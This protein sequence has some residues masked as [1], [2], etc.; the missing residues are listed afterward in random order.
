MNLRRL[1]AMLALSVATLISAS[2]QAVVQMNGDGSVGSSTPAYSGLWN[3]YEATRLFC[4]NDYAS[5][6]K[7]QSIVGAA[8]STFLTFSLGNSAALPAVA[9]AMSFFY[10]PASGLG[11]ASTAA[12]QAYPS[13]QIWVHGTG[14]IAFGA[15]APPLILDLV[16]G[17]GTGSQIIM[18]FMGNIVPAGANGAWVQY[19][20]SFPN[21][22]IIIEWV[23]QGG[24]V[25][26][27]TPGG[28]GN[29][30]AVL[31]ESGNPT[32]TEPQGPT[33][34]KI[35]FHYG[36][37]SINMPVPTGN[38]PDRT[39][40]SIGLKNQGQILQNPPGRSG[41]NLFERF[42]LMTEPSRYQTSSNVIANVT[43]INSAVGVDSISITGMPVRS[44]TG[45]TFVSELFAY[46]PL[47]INLVTGHITSYGNEASRYF[48]YGYPAISC[49]T[50][51]YRFMP[52]V[53]DIACVTDT[54]T[55]PP[56]I[57]A[58]TTLIPSPVPANLPLPAIQNGVLAYSY[59]LNTSLTVQQRFKNIGLNPVTSTFRVDVYRHGVSLPIT[60]VSSVPTLVN[61]NTISTIAFPQIT[62]LT[63]FNQPG[64]YTFKIYNI[65]GGVN[66]A[67]QNVENDTCE[68]RVYIRF[69]DDVMA[70]SVL[71][72]NQNTPPYYTRY[73]VGVDIP[74]EFRY[75]NIGNNT[76]V[77]VPV[78][79]IVYKASSGCSGTEVWRKDSV[80]ALT[81][82]YPW[83]P[84][85][86]RDVTF[87]A[88]SVNTPPGQPLIGFRPS[89][90]GK[91]YVK[92][93]VMMNGD[94]NRSNDTVP[95]F[96]RSYPYNNEYCL[97][98]PAPIVNDIGYEF[99][100][101]L[102]KS[103]SLNPGTPYG[104][105]FNACVGRVEDLYA[106][107]LNFGSND[108]INVSSTAVITQGSPTGTQVYSSTKVTTVVPKVSPTGAPGSKTQFYDK[109]VPNAPGIYYITVTAPQAPTGQN[110][111]QWVVLVG[112]PLAGSYRIGQGERF[113]SIQD[114]RDEL[115]R[116]GV[117][118]PVVFDLIE[119]Y[120]LVSPGNQNAGVSS[121]LD[122]PPYAPFLGATNTY[123]QTFIDPA[124]V[125]RPDSIVR[126]TAT[127]PALDFRGTISGASAV[128]TITFRPAVGKVNVH[129]RLA[130][131]SGIGIWYGQDIQRTYV[132]LAQPNR[133]VN[134]TGY[135]I[136]D[137]GADK[138][139]EFTYE[140]LTSAAGSMS[141]GGDNRYYSSIPFYMG[142]G[143]SNYT[144][145][146][147]KI[148][149][150]YVA[151]TGHNEPAVVVPNLPSGFSYNVLP[152]TCGGNPN[153][154]LPN[155]PGVPYFGNSLKIV[156]Q[157]GPID[158]IN[159]KLGTQTI[160]TPQYNQGSNLF[161][162]EPDVFITNPPK[163]G[164]TLSAGV[165]MRS[166]LP[167][168]GAGNNPLRWDTL[169]NN[170]N[171]IDNNEIEN[172]AYGVVSTGI[173]AI[174]N[175][176]FNSYL[177]YPNVGNTITNNFIH[178]V[179]RAGVAVEYDRK[180]KIER[181]TIVRVVNP[182]P[183]LNPVM[184]RLPNINF[185]NQESA[186]GVLISS[187]DAIG[188]APSIQ[189]RGY[190]T[191]LSINANTI[192]SI[193]ATSGNG[194]G[195]WSETAENVYIAPGG[196]VYRF[197][198]RGETRDTITNNFIWD[199]LGQN[200]QTLGRTF[201]IGFSLESTSEAA[202]P[203]FITSLNRIEN[204][205]IYN[206]N[207][208]A[209]KIVTYNS[210][211]ARLTREYGIGLWKASGWVR[212]N[213][214]AITGPSD[215][216]TL[217]MVPK[218]VGLSFM[219]TTDKPIISDY[220]LIY[221][222]HGKCIGNT[223][224]GYMNGFTGEYKWLD[225]ATGFNIPT[226]GTQGANVLLPSKSRMLSEW[227]FNT[228]LDSNS[229]WGV[230]GVQLL[231]TVVNSPL[232]NPDGIP[233]NI[234][235]GG[236]CR[237]I[238]D[239]F[240]NGT[241][242]YPD[243]VD[244]HM[245]EEIIGGLT[246]NRGVVIPYIK[247]DRDLDPRL[248]LT[249]TYYDIGADEYVGQLY[250]YDLM[251]ED[252]LNP[253]GFFEPNFGGSNLP[254][255]YVMSDTSINI[256]GRFRN[257]GGQPIIGDWDSV[258]LRIEALNPVP[259]VGFTEYTDIPLRV[260]SFTVSGRP[261]DA[262]SVI[263][264]VTFPAFKPRTIAEFGLGLLAP[265]PWRNSPNV[266][267]LYRI[268]I[269]GI[270]S[271]DQNLPNNKFTKFVR[272]YVP[273]STRS[274]MVGVKNF[275]NIP[276]PT[277]TPT[278]TITDSIA[279]KLNTDTLYAALT[280]INWQ[281]VDNIGLE[282][283]DVF[284]R[285]KWPENA[286]NFKMWRNI[287]WA[288]GENYPM[289]IDWRE[290]KAI[291]ECLN[292]GSTFAK[293]T[294]VIAGQEIARTHDVALNATNGL[295]SD[296]DFVRNYLR[297]R[298]ISK[299]TP[300]VYSGLNLIGK[301][302]TPGFFELINEA[303]QPIVLIPGSN[304]PQFAANPLITTSMF[305]ALG[306]P[307]PTPDIVRPILGPGAARST[308]NYFNLTSLPGDSASGVASNNPKWVTIF[309]A[310]DWRH[311]ARYAPQALYSGAPRVLLSSIDF[312]G[313]EG[314][315]PI[316]ITSFDA[317]QSGSQAVSVTWSTLS[318]VNVAGM[319]IQ[320]AIVDKSV[321][322]EKIGTYSTIERVSSKGNATTGAAYKIVDNNVK[323]GVEYS[324]RLVTSDLD[325]TRHNDG[326][327]HV[328]ISNAS[329]KGFSLTCSP[330]P[331]FSNGKL[332]IKAPAGEK[333]K[334]VIYNEL[335]K[336]VV[337]AFEGVVNTTEEVSI[338]DLKSGSYTARMENTKGVITEEKI[339]VSK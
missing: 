15:A 156:S 271:L 46:Y 58:P 263:K 335:G 187:G 310:I 100:V 37:N 252:I 85:Q 77:N 173:G 179:S 7:F 306:D 99:E 255:E 43:S 109:W 12:L 311:F 103:V 49:K 17:T 160:H 13:N 117:N 96:Y 262:A 166:I 192:R 4:G 105:Q 87:S 158:L 110:V 36:P 217:S 62:G 333:L 284:E 266:S 122:M 14:A 116:C 81:G 42:C 159:G 281:R 330:N 120:Y 171:V 176:S 238:V 157:C 326:E 249:S 118:A 282:D 22:R 31:F 181:N 64:T 229:V 182:S 314:V 67:D 195:I 272:F 236:L 273:R 219:T 140:N 323:S 254:A 302:V 221:M 244:L 32:V 303:G 33:C 324:Y 209:D 223:L 227:K 230:S 196:I 136:W 200:S 78:R 56:A 228:N 297:A 86:Y 40:A 278:G 11:A 47:A 155:T 61:P 231:A 23:S 234:P 16:K 107:M 213:I 113:R 225:A 150:L 106:T 318:E 44:I 260:D 145:K 337:I 338:N 291:K 57:P 48:H 53:N 172:F 325:G 164:M 327:K 153:V 226:P 319:E 74:I 232:Q 292:L 206:N 50:L 108:A 148:H 237:S 65:S 54:T 92:S 233:N 6:P 178:D 9:P 91:Y 307:N 119:D 138:R 35:L 189:K 25:T 188:G 199:Y 210:P 300:G 256:K 241:V 250:N 18:P 247:K 59:P 304:P 139:L 146:N 154:N 321:T 328:L 290:R 265:L 197:P 66:Y 202:N 240:Y 27:G 125:G 142:T 88:P 127:A 336:Q 39:G 243:S 30:Q 101:F 320:R 277:P 289:G 51:S 301:Q 165:Y 287:I 295:Q 90:P 93:F 112:N 283:Y 180:T 80:I 2:A 162:F 218:Q 8:N 98:N 52:T 329:T 102:D 135:I 143:A 151:R 211:T 63:W 315:L 216:L 248:S 82:T 28:V 294:L 203:K 264:E 308:H 73:N 208:G 267:P 285:D 174:Y 24:P 305:G 75:A 312:A 332:T 128:N 115:F 149:P 45:S 41:A 84:Q 293:K 194:A 144:V 339:I 274:T 133:F 131:F 275:Y 177:E 163:P 317:F 71:Q 1:L 204:N 212:N 205:T 276:V 79:C 132:P 29:F 313:S 10:L 170:S 316:K 246:N 299:T 235:S 186:A 279:N 69:P 124:W 224:Q 198:V 185:Y 161:T 134:P 251:A 89:S 288:Q 183:N 201:G 3:S 95:L 296:T 141:P 309:Y 331:V 5:G 257:I 34:G 123:K 280:A 94:Q 55:L 111:L 129:V 184:P 20:G 222:W 152:G 215:A 147:C 220:N 242:N 26:S 322:G 261:F 121:T 175:V 245:N 126:I 207:G 214:V 258:K 190:S 104:P 169:Q 239:G 269:E 193:D 270:W 70:H 286:L 83:G 72:P 167:T 21:R 60:S 68:I 130:S 97:K 114:A 137:G 259:R 268:T 334:V 168:T 298:Y 253:Q 38:Q 76:E 191:E 19:T